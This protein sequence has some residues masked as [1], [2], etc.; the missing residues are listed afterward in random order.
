MGIWSD[1]ASWRGPTPNHGG[2][3]VRYDY[4]VEH[5]A[6][7][8]FE[9]T[10]AWQKNAASDTSSHFVVAKDGRIAQMLDTR[11]QAWTQ[12]EGNPYSVSIENEGYTGQQLTA[13]QVEANAQLLARAHR[14]HGVPVQVTTRVGTP[15]LAHHSMGFES[16]VN[17][18]HQF[19]PGEP[20]KAQKATIVQRAL[21]I[22]GGDMPGYA[23]SQPEWADDDVWRGSSAAHMSET[24]E[25]GR[26]AGQPNEMVRA[27]KDIRADA[28][29][30]ATRD[31][32]VTFDDAT[33]ADIAARV[34]VALAADET[35][36][37]TLV[38]AAFD[39]AQRAERE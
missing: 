3:V 35:F 27:V 10:I 34:A 6:D 28:H 24:I 12:I 30:A 9:G 32:P 8:G 37:E 33:V 26:Y 14:E 21:D 25:G 20:V 17:W 7:G 18:G 36:R 4:V 31:V 22:L 11:Y 29:T 1:I 19:C 39:G 38:A 16:G 2:F 5:I 23:A 15:G 13:Q